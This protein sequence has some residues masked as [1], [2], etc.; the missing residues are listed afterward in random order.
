MPVQHGHEHMPMPP[1]KA[2]VDSS[3]IGVAERMVSSRHVG[4]ATI[5]GFVILVAAMAVRAA[6]A[7]SVNPVMPI[8]LKQGQTIEM[9]MAGH[10]LG[11]IAAAPV[12]DARGLSIEVVKPQKPN[13]NEV[14]LRITATADATPGDRQMR[15]IGPMG[16][17]KP[18]HVFV[19]QYPVINEKEPNSAPEQAK[20]VELP[21]T[22]LGRIDAPGDVEQFRF[23]A[24]KG[25]K[26]IFDA[27]AARDGSPL[28]LVATIHSAEGREMR[29]TVERRGGDPVLIFDVP[30]EGDYRLRL[31]DL[32]Y[33]GGGDYN[34]RV[35][36]GA[37][38][39]VEALLPSSGEPGGTITARAI[40]YNLEGADRITIDLTH[41][42]PGRIEV[43]AK[44]PA[45]FSNPMPFEV[46]EL[47]QTVEFEPNNDAKTANAITLPAEVSAHVDRP[48][49]EDFFK[50]HLAY[51][52]VVNLEVLAGRYGS[53]V[54]P[55]LQLRDAQGNA[56]ERNDGTPDA[57]ARIVRELEAG[58]YFVSVR[59]LTYA[60]GP[61]YWYRLKVEPAMRVPQDFAV[62][63]LPDAPRLHR[64]GNVP[65]WCEVK[66]LNGFK[67]DV[68]ITP[69]GLSSGVA[70]TGPIVLGPDTSGWFT[71]AAAPDAA[72]GPVPIRLRATS[73][74]G[75]VPVTHYAEPE[76]DGRAVPDAYLTVL[77]PSPFKV[78]AVA[79]LTPQRLQ[80]MN[81]EIGQ[82]AAKVNAP[83][84]KFDAS[85]TAWAK[86]AAERPTWTVLNPAT[87]SSA[88]GTPL[89]RQPDGSVMASGNVP[90]QDVFT[91]TANT[92]L[93]GIT[94][95]RLEV[96][97]DERLPG[98]GPGAASNGNFVLSAFKLLAGKAGQPPQ[99][100]AIK[101][102]S[103]DFSQA[104]FPVLNAIQTK[105]DSGWAVMPEFGKTHIAIFVLA[106]PI[107]ADD[108]TTLTFVLEQMTGFANHLV[109]RFRLS[110]TTADPAL[111][112]TAAELPR[113]ITGIVSIPADQR[114]TEQR[115]DLAAYFRTINPDTAPARMRLDAMR[116]YVEPYAE[117]QRLEAVLKTE[118][119]QL[120]KEQQAWEQQ[121]AVGQGWSLL[122]VTLA[123]SDAG[124]RLERQPDGSWFANGDRPQ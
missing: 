6:P 70:P 69:E 59:D 25:Q 108:A 72:L 94:A 50:F 49:D 100:V 92:D 122:P 62:R 119:P 36:A 14:R 114:T 58:D 52:Q 45:G 75:D 5:A 74:V 30:E 57:D 17:T 105:P 115:N 53:P 90:P 73:M 103:A 124:V 88:K 110:V 21:A 106:S 33:R 107:G 79:T 68:T 120:Q 26:L 55:L 65:V 16:V 46:T 89:V 111:L 66:R 8:A 12:A 34:Y 99:P 1:V 48:G 87:A 29:T 97:A 38:P 121:M 77:E 113:D 43:R 31:R 56:I 64:G 20:A 39:Y 11:G 78:E 47:P 27:C 37:I 101:S 15:L 112:G 7:P 61:G 76:L 71:L 40:G 123:K 23:H 96:I 109:G 18:I 3:L 82:L 19:S 2:V 84:P 104:N 41:T 98:R 116:S 85:L 9:S 63:F 81:T 22:L 80:Q 4:F 67:G 91:V 60:G 93:K 42:A 24:S 32:Q 51:K 44:T 54:T 102:A 83:D 35:L 118:T 95:V 86:K 10:E 13:P 28:D 117:I